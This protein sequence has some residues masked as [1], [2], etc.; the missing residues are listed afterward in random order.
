[1]EI[2]AHVGLKKIA[3]KKSMKFVEMYTFYDF[4]IINKK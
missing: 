2:L 4:S 1:M 3:L